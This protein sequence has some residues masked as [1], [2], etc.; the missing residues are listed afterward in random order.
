MESLPEGSKVYLGKI[1]GNLF[2]GISLDSSS[3]DIKDKVFIA[4]KSVNVK[5]KFSSLIS[6][7]P[8]I[9]E[10]KIIKP[11]IIIKSQNAVKDKKENKEKSVQ[12]SISL[13][14]TQIPFEKIF[15]ENTHEILQNIIAKIPQFQIEKI[16]I[17]EISVKKGDENVFSNG[18]IELHVF[19]GILKL[20]KIQGILLDKI[21][22]KNIS[23]T[24]NYDKTSLLINELNFRTPNSILTGKVDVDFAEKLNGLWIIDSLGV[25]DKALKNFFPNSKKVFKNVVLSSAGYIYFYTDSIFFNISPAGN[26][27]EIEIDSSKISGKIGKTS[28]QIKKLKV[29]SPDGV[30]SGKMLSGFKLK[31]WLELNIRKFKLDKLNPGIDSSLINMNFKINFDKWDVNSLN[32][33]LSINVFDSYINAAKFKKITLNVDAVKG[34]YAIDSTSGVY[35]TEESVFNLSGNFNGKLKGEIDLKFEDANFTRLGEVIGLEKLQGFGSGYFKFSGKLTDPDLS[36]YLLLD[37][38]GYANIKCYGI[39]E[40][41]QVENILGK[42]LGNYKL[43][44]LS[45]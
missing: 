5:H 16:K 26:F 41:I 38:L 15:P 34:E 25:N 35:F 22:I 3:F 17:K 18:E 20:H 1:N 11:E 27:N 12:T 31:T 29:W 13:E 45:G 43:D 33:K 19:P 36:S 21:P 7:I 42:R 14:K 24:C 28:L 4:V 32:G 39:E 2:S 37:S 8:E 40:E 30:L 23:F 10:I 6:G 44:I 9:K